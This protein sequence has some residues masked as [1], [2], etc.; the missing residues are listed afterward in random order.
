MEDVPF[1]GPWGVVAKAT[2]KLAGTVDPGVGLDRASGNG[3]W[4]D[5]PTCPTEV[6]AS[7]ENRA[8]TSPSEPEEGG[9]TC[10]RHVSAGRDPGA[11]LVP[12]SP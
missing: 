4:Q 6:V 3:R 1:S 10:R 8:W 12:S 9:E 7:E 11:G 2:L 5:V